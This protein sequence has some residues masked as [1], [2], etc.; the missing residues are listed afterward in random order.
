[1]AEKEPL[2]PPRAPRGLKKKSGCE[3]AD[4]QLQH[5][6]KHG[7]AHPAITTEIYRRCAA[8]VTKKADKRTA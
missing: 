6:I 5:L 2:F 1:M 4:L 8:A 7:Y 3:L